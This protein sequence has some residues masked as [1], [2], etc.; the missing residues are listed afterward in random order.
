[1]QG[2]PLMPSTVIRSFSYEPGKGRLVIEFLSGRRYAYFNVPPEIQAGLR[3]ASSR[4]S[5]FNT[6]VRDRYSWSR[7][8]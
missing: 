4:G 1:M 7:L 2:L 5:Y 3:S 6:W 8:H